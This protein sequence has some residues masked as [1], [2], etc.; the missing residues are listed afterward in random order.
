MDELRI[1][2]L[3]DGTIKVET[4]EVSQANHASAEAFLRLIN[5]MCGG[6]QSRK[7]KAHAHVHGHAKHHHKH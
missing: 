6:E 5:Q 1:E 3:P 2:I 4:D 7:R